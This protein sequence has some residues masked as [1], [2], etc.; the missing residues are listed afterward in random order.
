ML[1]TRQIYNSI[2]IPDKYK[3]PTDYIMTSIKGLESD[4]IGV[5]PTLDGSKIALD[6]KGR[7]LQ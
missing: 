5:N 6:C 7:F 4:L 2:A 1:I 3:Q